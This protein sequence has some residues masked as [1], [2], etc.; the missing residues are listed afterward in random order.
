MN[1][2]CAP[3]Y[4]RKSIFRYEEKI[5]Q[6]FLKIIL[7]KYLFINPFTV[8]LEYIRL[9]IHD[10]TPWT[11]SIFVSNNKILLHNVNHEYTRPS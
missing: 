5:N 2:I 6:I 9:Y 4:G 7:L 8:I 3:K 1:V 10:I 11:P